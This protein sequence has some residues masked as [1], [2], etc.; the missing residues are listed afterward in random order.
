[1][2]EDQIL[3]LGDLRVT[4]L[5]YSDTS[6]FRREQYQMFC[7]GRKQKLFVILTLGH[8]WFH[9]NMTTDGYSIISSV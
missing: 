8:I 5:L 9:Y 2:E 6:D 1:M 4:Y 7:S 3:V